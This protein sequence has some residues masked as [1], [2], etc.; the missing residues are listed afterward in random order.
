MKLNLLGKKLLLLNAINQN[1]TH[2]LFIHKF[3]YFQI[4]INN[5]IKLPILFFILDSYSLN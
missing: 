4:R 1:L 2:N 3:Y 5:H